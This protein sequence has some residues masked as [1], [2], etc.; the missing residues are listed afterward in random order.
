M[1]DNEQLNLQC[2][3]RNACINGDLNTIKN[4]DDK[5]DF[6]EY[7]DFPLR[8][9][10]RN[11]HIEICKFLINKKKADVGQYTYEAILLAVQNDHKEVAKYL[12]QI[13]KFGH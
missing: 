8:L 7:N 2:R 13:A 4:L 10:A 3:L 12:M 11:G 1:I 5:V 9:A 6:R